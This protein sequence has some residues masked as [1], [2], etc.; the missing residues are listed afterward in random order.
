[1]TKETTDNSIISDFDISHFTKFEDAKDS[2]I[3][4]LINYDLNRKKLENIPHLRYL[5]FAVT[6]FYQIYSDEESTAGIHITNEHLKMWDVTTET[7]YETAGQNTPRLLPYSFDSMLN[8]LKKMWKESEDLLPSPEDLSLPLYVLTNNANRYGATCLLY[9]DLLENIK[10]ELGE[11]YYILPSSIHELI[12]LP[13]SYV[14]SDEEL[15]KMVQEVNATAVP[16]NE[17]LSD[18]AFRYIDH[19]LQ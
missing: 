14:T 18:H 16:E 12:I 3:F 4:R 7:L 2:I 17:I 8:I 6:F 15:D 10:N 11:D 13:A 9:D 5:E 19:E 1:M